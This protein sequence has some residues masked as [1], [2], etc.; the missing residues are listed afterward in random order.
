MVF[1]WEQLQLI[2]FN[3]LIRQNLFTWGVKLNPKT[4]LWDLDIGIKKKESV[5]GLGNNYLLQPLILYGTPTMHL[6][7]GNMK[8]L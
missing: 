4:L 5:V 7:M 8:N 3:T 1:Y 2:L 6:F